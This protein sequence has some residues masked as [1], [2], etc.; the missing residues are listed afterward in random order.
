MGK[1]ETPG[2]LQRQ[3]QNR[4]MLKGGTRAVVEVDTGPC[5]EAM[6]ELIQVWFVM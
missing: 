5:N 1:K 2:I 6:N 3:I 4:T